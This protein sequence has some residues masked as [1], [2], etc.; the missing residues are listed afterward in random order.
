MFLL[1]K[2]EALDHHSRSKLRIQIESLLIDLNEEVFALSEELAKSYGHGEPRGTALARAREFEQRMLVVMRR[3]REDI[4]DSHSV[5]LVRRH[6]KIASTSPQTQPNR[7]LNTFG[8]DTM[9]SER[10]KARPQAESSFTRPRYAPR[11]ASA[12][13]SPN[14]PS[15]RR[16]FS[17]NRLP[18]EDESY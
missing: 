6:A 9:E 17:S 4:D 2:D 5:K 12:S 3:V 16:K 13:R 18:A 14:G 8:A 1:G 15:L 11:P 7:N 10:N